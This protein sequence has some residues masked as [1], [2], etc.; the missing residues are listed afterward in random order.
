MVE[1]RR[2]RFAAGAAAATPSGK[3]EVPHLKHKTGAPFLSLS[4]CESRSSC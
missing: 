3:A 4:R 1:V 2:A